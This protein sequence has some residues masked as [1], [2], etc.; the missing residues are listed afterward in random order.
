MKNRNIFI[1]SVGR[2][3][4]LVKLFDRAKRKLNINGKI[5]GGDMDLN[6][7]AMHFVDKAIQLP[8]ISEKNYISEI[9]KISKQ[10]KIDLIIPTI[11]TE[12]LI[13][14]QNREKIEKEAN[15]KINLSDLEFIE[16]CRDKYKTQE[17]FEKNGFGVPKLITE[18]MIVENNYTFPLF[19]KPLNGSS[20]INTFKIN[21]QK[22]LEFFKEYVPNPIIQE[23]IV[24][25][26]F[27]VDV[28]CDFENNPITIVPRKRLATRSGEI[29]KGQVTKDREIIDDIKKFLNYF[30]GKGHI[31]IQCMKT[32]NGIKYIEINPRFGGGAPMSIMAGADS[33]ENLYKILLGESLSYNEEYEELLSLRYDEAIF[34]TKNGNVIKNV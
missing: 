12:L 18:Q 29:S 13:L 25:D 27:T 3:V 33:P 30:K 24:G 16:I 10:E 9:I 6:A 20:S 15:V 31:T 23:C 2:R 34:I 17:F 14:A 28:F 11:D 32:K 7:P 21:T 5:I 26:E 4:E 1:L 22:E 19:I 8:K